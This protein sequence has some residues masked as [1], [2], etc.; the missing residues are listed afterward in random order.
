MAQA[1]GAEMLRKLLGAES[2]PSADASES[3]RSC[4]VNA[5]MSS[6]SKSNGTKQKADPLDT[7]T[8]FFRPL[9][10]LLEDGDA[11]YT[12]RFLDKPSQENDQES[13]ALAVA[14]GTA[15]REITVWQT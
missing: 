1:F 11:L 7:D 13:D 6:E 10:E 2:I 3:S 14:A 4:E 12:L 5:C 8:S 9:E 15:E